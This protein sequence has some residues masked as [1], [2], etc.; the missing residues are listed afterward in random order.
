MAQDIRPFEQ[1]FGCVPDRAPTGLCIT[2]DVE[3]GQRPRLRNR[4][5]EGTLAVMQRTSRSMA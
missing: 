5:D 2:R 4:R 1:M 3:V